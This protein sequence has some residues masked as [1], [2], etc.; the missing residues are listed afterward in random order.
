[1]DNETKFTAPYVPF[2]TF[3]TGLDKLAAL[4]GTI[5][6]KIDHTVFPSMGGIAKG[7]VISA[8]K[9]LGLID[10]NGLP[11]RSL[12]DLALNKEGRKAAMRKLIAKCYPNITEA[13]L[14]GSSPSHLDSKLSD[15]AYNISGAT[16]QKARAFLLKA[17]EFSGIPLSKLL[18][19]KGPR[20]PRKKRVGNGKQNAGD[21]PE[22]KG[23][24]RE[25]KEN[26]PL[27]PDSIRMPIA[28]GPE[29]IAY[30]ELPK[31]L[32]PKEITRLLAILKLSLGEE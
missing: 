6:P 22:Q 19:Q 15:K 23:K 9:F 21:K 12:E 11:D 17:A 8:M 14:A 2:S 32:E 29:R 30:I 24:E 4:G 16:K 3:E 26:P 25:P 27:D 20:G 5:P 10:A 13:D 7:Q 31:N 1:M 18:T 28:L